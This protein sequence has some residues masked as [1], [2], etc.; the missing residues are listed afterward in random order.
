MLSIA[1]CRRILNVKT[2]QI[3]DDEVVKLRDFLYL[4]AEIEVE[5]V[6]KLKNEKRTGVLSGKH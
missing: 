2:E 1:E 6:Q 3:N 4:I 5:H